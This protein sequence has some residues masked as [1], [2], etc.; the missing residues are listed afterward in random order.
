MFYSNFESKNEGIE[1]SGHV[2]IRTNMLQSGK[3]LDED[4]KF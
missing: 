2:S 4:Q 1:I 3:G